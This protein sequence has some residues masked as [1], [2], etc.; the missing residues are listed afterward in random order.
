MPYLNVKKETAR[1]LFICFDSV[2]IIFN[3]SEFLCLFNFIFGSP[4]LMIPAVAIAA[5]YTTTIKNTTN[6]T[7]TYHITSSHELQHTPSPHPVF[8]RTSYFLP[9]CF[10]HPPSPPPPSFPTTVET[11]GAPTKPSTKRD[12]HNLAILKFSSMYKK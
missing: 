2:L 5:V 8:V 7:T 3:I 4:Y 9:S 1:H 11:L 12:H 10:C 6:T